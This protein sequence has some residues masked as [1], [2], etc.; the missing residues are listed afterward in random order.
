MKI[1]LSTN[2]WPCTQ[3]LLQSS[4]NTW[5]LILFILYTTVTFI[6]L[7]DHCWFISKPDF[8]NLYLTPG[9]THNSALL[10]QTYVPHV[11]RIENNNKSQLI[12]TDP[13]RFTII[14]NNSYWRSIGTSY[15]QTSP[16]ERRVNIHWSIPSFVG[17]CS[18]S[19]TLKARENLTTHNIN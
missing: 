1:K 19:F 17:P 14:T 18:G 16:S 13:R 11:F 2:F 4:H 7:C 9:N 3:H 8:I 5:S 12:L 10:V 6:H 15:T